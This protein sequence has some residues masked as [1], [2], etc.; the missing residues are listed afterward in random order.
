M[1]HNC[2]YIPP[3]CSSRL[4]KIL[5]SEQARHLWLEEKVRYEDRVAGWF[6]VATAFWGVVAAALTAGTTLLLLRP[7]WTRGLPEMA[8]GRIYPL[9]F[10]MAIFGFA[11]NGVFAAIYYSTQRLCQRPMFSASLGYLHFLGW[12]FVTVWGLSSLAFGHMQ[13]RHGAEFVWPVDVGI[14][15]VWLVFAVNFLA[16]VFARK[17]RHMYISLW[18][19][20]TSAIAVLPVFVLNNLA[21]AGA[22]YESTSVFSGVTDAFMQSWGQQNLLVYMLVMPLVGVLY[23]FVPRVSGQPVAN[24]RLAIAQFWMMTFLGLLA[25]PRLLHFTAVPEWVSSVAMLAGVLMFM[26]SWV[27]VTN[28]MAMAK[29]GRIEPAERVVVRFF[30]VGILFYAFLCLES[31]LTSIKSLAAMTVFTDW[32][33]AN[34]YAICFGF[35]AFMTMGVANWLAPL[36][37]RRGLWNA[38]L[39]QL[40]FWLSTAGTLLLVGSTY[41]GGLTQGWMAHSLDST[42]TL[43]YP[44]FIEIVQTA[45]LFWW[46]A[47]VGAAINFAAMLLFAL[48]V[49]MTWLARKR[50]SEPT[51]ESVRRLADDYQDPPPP[52]SRLEGEA[53]L[54]LGVKLDIWSKLV[55]HRRWERSSSRFVMFVAILILVGV[56]VEVAPMWAWGNSLSATARPVPYTPL[57]LLGRDIFVREGCANCHTQTV[58]PLVAETKRY[59]EFT[60]AEQFHFDRPAA[61]GTRRIGP[62]LAREGGARDGYWHWRHLQNP[63]EVNP[64]SV[65]PSFAH[66]MNQELDLAAIRTLVRRAAELGV[67][68]DEQWLAEDELTEEERAEGEVTELERVVQQQAEVM[69]A[70]I[71]KAGGPAAKF[72]RQAIALIAFL[73]RLG[74]PPTLDQ[75]DAIDSIGL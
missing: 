22:G 46:G 43:V 26:P 15:L 5:E 41:T 69:A 21:I 35:A 10:N 75:G 57:E 48:N 38:G 4:G 68:Y 20:I 25:G 18:F 62:D 74:N 1:Q 23:Y 2:T 11:A 59:G 60:T 61:W 63:Q 58:R 50:E 19:Y 33:I 27:G 52:K 51:L 31:A 8:F 54:N 71:V 49:G 53:I 44:E 42:G 45:S 30:Q 55:W 72:D 28:G 13:F 32:S 36:I 9:H 17:Q 65:M 73:Q 24:Y 6:L 39:T 47:V 34:S 12:Q 56:A 3:R 67:P 40:H 14:A 70:D 16:T 37:F 66:M 29:A 7:E 64:G